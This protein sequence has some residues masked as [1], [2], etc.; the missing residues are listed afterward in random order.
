MKFVALFA[1]LPLLAVAAPTQRALGMPLQGDLCMPFQHDLGTP[2]QDSDFT[3]FAWFEHNS[4]HPPIQ[5][6]G[7]RFWLGGEPATYCPQ[8]PVV[9]CPPGKVTAL[10]V[11]NSRSGLSVNVPGGQ[12]IYVSPTGELGYTQAHSAF[13]PPGSFLGPFEHTPG[14]PFGRYTFDGKGFI[15]CPNSKEDPTTWKVFAH[16]P[17]A[18]VPTGDIQDCLPFQAV[19]EIFGSPPAAWQYI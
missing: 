18:I 2:L 3:A 10:G 17:N 1:A 6:R 19:T 16:I 9:H 14:L 7:L 15:A 11:G 12:Q 13:I 4:I 8:P 5:A